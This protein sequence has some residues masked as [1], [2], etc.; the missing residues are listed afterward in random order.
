MTRR[1]LLRQT[2]TGTDASVVA[3]CLGPSPVP[4]WGAVSRFTTVT[5]HVLFEGVLDLLAGVFEVGLGLVALA[6]I[7]G[8]LVAG[9]PADRFLGLTAKLLGL[10]SPY[11]YR[12][13]SAPPLTV[14]AP[15]SRE[16]A[17]GGRTSGRWVPR[18]PVVKT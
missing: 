10:V 3:Y 13:L 7:F 9:D 8:A 12:T 2:P 11:P 1:G 17:R 5:R 16:S 15:T 18:G 14:S 6:L 4:P